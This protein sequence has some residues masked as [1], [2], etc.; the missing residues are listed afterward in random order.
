MS[1]NTQIAGLPYP[2]LSDAPDVPVDMQ[3]L[4][5]ALEH[6]VIPKYATASAQTSANPA[7][8]DGD[9][10]YRQDLS[11]GFI[12]R[13][14]SSYVLGD[15]WSKFYESV[16][17]SGGATFAIPSIPQY[18]KSLKI[19]ISAAG[20]DASSGANGFND[21]GLQFNGDT[22]ANYSFHFSYILNGSG[23]SQAGTNLSH[24]AHCGFVPVVPAAQASTTEILISNYTSTTNQKTLVFNSFAMSG[25][26]SPNNNQVGSG[27]AIWSGL[28]AI[29]SI[30]LYVPVTTNTFTQNSYCA[31]YGIG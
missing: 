30:L 18:F 3:N 8:A 2:A 20:T 11:Q 21:I 14:S 6:L 9:T 13:G 10:W 25:V 26:G 19:I 31:A 24:A 27:G 4:A 16:V 23:P 29:T 22:G 7:P 1:S 15:S 17:P 28:G 12:Q 5:Q